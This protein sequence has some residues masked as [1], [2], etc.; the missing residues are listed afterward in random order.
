MAR[1]Y[2]LELVDFEQ[3]GRHFPSALY[4]CEV[5]SYLSWNDCVRSHL[6][7]FQE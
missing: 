2:I 1:D 4:G 7:Y 3:N 6:M 5:S